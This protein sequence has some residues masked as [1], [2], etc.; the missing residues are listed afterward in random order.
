MAHVWQAISNKIPRRHNRGYDVL[1]QSRR[2]W[3]HVSNKHDILAF[4]M[5]LDQNIYTTSIFL[6]VC[7]QAFA[8]KC[9]YLRMFFGYIDA[10]IKEEKIRTS[11]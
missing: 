11:L 6:C 8:G 10:V 1:D 9:R 3:D 4:T 7:L 2:L 5:S